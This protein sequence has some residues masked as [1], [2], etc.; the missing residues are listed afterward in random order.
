MTSRFFASVT[1]TAGYKQV[2]I[3]MNHPTTPSNSIGRTHMQVSAGCCAAASQGLR[4]SSP[5]AETG[6]RGSAFRA[7]RASTTPGSGVVVALPASR[8]GVLT[9]RRGLCRVLANLDVVACMYDGVC[10]MDS[11]ATSNDFFFQGP[12]RDA[13]GE[14]LCSQPL[15]LLRVRQ[16]RQ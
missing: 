4:D 10:D 11:V 3:R 6:D 5:A 14:R 7:C 2:C 1:T 16:Q 13:R 9:S 12:R 15:V 8:L